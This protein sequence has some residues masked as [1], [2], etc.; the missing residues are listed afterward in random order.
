[1]FNRTA[2]RALALAFAL[3]I[4]AVLAVIGI[5]AIPV[6]S[7]PTGTTNVVPCASLDD[8]SATNATGGV[9]YLP[10]E[11]NGFPDLDT[12]AYGTDIQRCASDDY[13]STRLPR[14]Y[15]ESPDAVIIFDADDNRVAT[16]NK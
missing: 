16:I 4:V 13:N 5:T 15:T 1:M 6:A 3:V 14:C 10:H 9:C 12:S 7:A 2:P 11:W 8:G